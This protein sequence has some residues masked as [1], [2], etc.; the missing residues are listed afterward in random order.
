MKTKKVTAITVGP[1]TIESEVT[2]HDAEIMAIAIQVAKII[3]FAK[4]TNDSG[5]ALSIVDD[6]L[7]ELRGNLGLHFKQSGLYE[8]KGISTLFFLIQK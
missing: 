2:D 1:V 7:S 4:K 5:L 8:Q 6:K 3:K